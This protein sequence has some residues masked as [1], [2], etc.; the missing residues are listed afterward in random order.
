MDGL[1]EAMAGEQGAEAAEPLRRQVAM[2]LDAAHADGGGEGGDALR[3]GQVGDADGLRARGRAA[4][5]AR[6][7][8]GVTWS[9]ARWVRP[10]S[11]PKAVAPAAW[12]ASASVGG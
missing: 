6:D 3:V 5:M 7:W 2:G 12:A 9:S 10:Q 1:D 8:S 11:T 4:M